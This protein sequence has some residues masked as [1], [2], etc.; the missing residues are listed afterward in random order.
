[1]SVSS[2]QVQWK[3]LLF[4]DLQVYSRLA[5]CALKPLNYDF[6]IVCVFCDSVLNLTLTFKLLNTKWHPITESSD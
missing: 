2:L 5:L 1:M 3:V 4:P 6:L